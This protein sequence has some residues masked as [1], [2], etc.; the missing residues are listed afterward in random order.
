MQRNC[1]ETTR[2]I[3]YSRIYARPLFGR[4]EGE[5]ADERG[6]NTSRRLVCGPCVPAAATRFV[7]SSPRLGLDTND[8]NS[9]QLKHSSCAVYIFNVRLV[10]IGW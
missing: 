5:R 7:D 10:N 6:G 9:R 4:G 2:V 3:K 8:Y 1:I